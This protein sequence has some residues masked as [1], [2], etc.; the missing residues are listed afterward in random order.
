MSL[1]SLLEMYCKF[2]LAYQFGWL[3][4]EISQKMANGRLLFQAL[5]VRSLFKPGTHLPVS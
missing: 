3:N 4:P 1:D 5:Y 2:V